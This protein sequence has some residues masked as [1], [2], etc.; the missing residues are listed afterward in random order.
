MDINKAKSLYSRLDELYKDISRN[1][2]ITLEKIKT[3][4]INLV[5]S[6]AQQ[7]FEE[8]RNI[9]QRI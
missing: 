2:S 9:D 4:K 3:L 6:L 1:F 5:K 8:L 7:D